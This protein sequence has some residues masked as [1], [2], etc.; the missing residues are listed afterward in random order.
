MKWRHALIYLVLLLG[1][2]GFYYFQTLKEAEKEAAEKAAQRIFGHR[3][4][5]LEALE[6]SREG[7]ETL[8]VIKDGVWRITHPVEAPTDEF[9]MESYVETLVQLSREREVEV[10]PPGDLAVFG[11]EKPGLRIRFLAQGQWRELLLG[12]KNPLGDAFYAATAGSPKIFLVSAGVGE[13]L[14]KGLHDLRNKEVLSFQPQ[15]VLKLEL[16]WHQGATVTLTRRGE[17]GGKSWVAP[18]HPERKIKPSKVENAL[19]QLQWLRARNFLEEAAV[20]MAAHGLDPALVTIRLERSERDPL[21][22][23]I[24]RSEA[25]PRVLNA[26]SSHLAAVVEI[27]A[28]PLDDMPRDLT[29]LEDRSLWTGNAD[30]VTRLN[31]ALQEKKGQVVRQEKNQWAFLDEA[32]E[33]SPL[34]E[35]WLAQSLLWHIQDMEYEEELTR[36]QEAADRDVKMEGLPN[37]L[38]FQADAKS[39]LKISWDLPAGDSAK[40]ETVWLQR[41][42]QIQEVRLSPEAWGKLISGIESLERAR[43]ER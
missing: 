14:F 8:K 26:F 1:A 10:E 31:W 30:Q 15:E 39:L 35:S 22:L 4:E 20:N 34:K 16:Q 9:A 3:Q 37:F 23:K 41:D 36:P 40:P 6:I 24:G 32:G 21:V 42:E 11:L 25:N 12:D 18:E 17:E 5:D 19:Q 33:R 27:D 7:E 38:E 43:E 29:A 2:G 28:T 13:G